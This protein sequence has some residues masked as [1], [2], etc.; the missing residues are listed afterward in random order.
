MK[1]V[2]VHGLGRSRLSLL[3]LAR[4]LARSGHTPQLFPYSALFETYER[5]VL[6][7]VN[8][9]RQLEAQGG[10]VGLIGHSFGGLLLREALSA[11]ANL[12][13]KHLIMLATPNRQPRLG[14]RVYT[15]LPFRWF[16]GSCGQ[17]LTDASWFRSLAVPSVPYTIVAGMRGW[18]GH[19]GPF[20]GEPNDGIVAVSE[21]IIQD[22]DRPVLVPTI[23]T[24]IMN[25]RVVHRLIV[26]KF[27][28]E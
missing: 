16:R 14:L 7:L 25:S 27:S 21:T 20:N 9:L 28:A 12:R 6:R 15:R 3:L 1:V 24:F 2:L 4:R 5:V 18:R 22:T 8:R 13:V 10:E 19:R 11:V 26:E 17:R 23:H